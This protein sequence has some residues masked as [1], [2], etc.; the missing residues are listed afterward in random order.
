MSDSN[1]TNQAIRLL[2][3]P[4]NFAVVQLPDR[5]FPGIVVQGDTLHGLVGRLGEVVRSLNARHLD[6]L[7][8]ELDDMKDQLAE[9]LEHYE[10]VCAKHGIGLPYLRP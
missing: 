7:S 2:S 8:A 9:A 6:D 1:S 5:A 4:I 3:R 10:H